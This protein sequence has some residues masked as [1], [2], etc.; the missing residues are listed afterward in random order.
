MGIRDEGDDGKED[1][2]GCRDDWIEG[3]AGEKMTKTRRK[4]KRRKLGRISC[5][6]AQS[7]ARVSPNPNMTSSSIDG[8]GDDGGERGEEG[9]HR[10][11]YRAIL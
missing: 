7:H 11:C 1:D 2:D 6:L 3:E 8:G 10:D 4:K 9:G 5:V